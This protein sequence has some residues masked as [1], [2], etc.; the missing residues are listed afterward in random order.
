MLFLNFRCV[1]SFD[2]LLMSFFQE[3]SVNCLIC[4][5]KKSNDVEVKEQVALTGA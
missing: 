5:K 4:L 3:M 2:Y 1:G